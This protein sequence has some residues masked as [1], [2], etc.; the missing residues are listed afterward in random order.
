MARYPFMT[1]VNEHMGRMKEMYQPITWETMMRRYIRMNKDVNRL[2]SEEKISTTSPKNMTVDDVRA[3]L[4][5]RRSL[6]YSS[7]E[8][9]HD[10]SA[11]KSLFK[12]VKNVAFEECMILYPLL[13]AR[14]KS[15]RLPPLEDSTYQKIL[16]ISKNIEPHDF[17]RTR[18]YCL[19]LLCANIG[20]RTKEIHLSN[21]N[22]IDTKEWMFDIIHV[23]GEHTYG[24]QRSVPIHPEAR[25][26]LES[27][28]S[29]RENWLIANSMRSD[30][31]F[32]SSSSEDGRLTQNSL[33]RIKGIVESD[34]GEKFDFRKLRRTYG[35]QLIDSDVDIESVSVMMGHA[36]T[37]TT[38][39][40][41]ARKRNSA[42]IAKVKST[43]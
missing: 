16:E 8:Y 27:Y 24:E 35:Q 26:I 2:H 39:L 3:Y 17:K 5:Y 19:V 41:Y 23:K 33:N 20:T 18:A 21:V 25:P 1:Y 32:P 6:N 29:L 15:T 12:S 38:E 10:E 28:L 36:T 14:K 9:S 4:S 13:K 11:L 42:A 34:I 7:K 30:A 31:L 43:W 37:R 22:D 40:S